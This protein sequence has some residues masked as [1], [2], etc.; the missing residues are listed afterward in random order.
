MRH[1]FYF[2][3]SY[4]ALIYAII[5]G[6]GL[7]SCLYIGLAIHTKEILTTGCGEDHYE[8]WPS[9][10]STIGDMMPERQTWRIAFVLC[11]PFRLGA[12]ISL[13][14]VFW[15]RS[16][17]GMSD[18]YSFRTSMKMFVSSSAFLSLLMFWV[19][20]WRLVGACIW[21]MVASFESLSYHNL[22]FCPYIFL[23]FV[24]QLTLTAL[25]RRNRYN[26]AIYPTQQDASRSLLLKRICLW[27]ETVAS[28]GVVCSYTY[29]FSTCANGSFSMSNMFEWAFGACNIIYDGSAWYDLKQ[30]GWWL[31]ATPG[32]YR[33]RW[34]RRSSLLSPP[35]PSVVV[36]GHGGSTTAAAAKVGGPTGKTD[37]AA[38][39]SDNVVIVPASPTPPADGFAN[40]EKEGF[41]GSDATEETVALTSPPRTTTGEFFLDHDVI[42]HRFSFCSAPSRLSLWLCDIYWAHFFFEMVVHLIEHMYFMPLIAMSLSWEMSSILVIGIPCLLRIGK[43]RRWATGPCPFAR[44]WLKPSHVPIGLSY[45]VVPM[46]VFFY[47]MSCLSHLHQVVLHDPGKKILVV[48]A[49]PLFLY[50]GLFTRFLYPSTVMLKRSSSEG[51]EDSRR[52]TMATPL[53]LVLCMLLRFLHVGVSPFYTVPFYGCIFGIVLGLTF[54]TVIYRHAMFGNALKEEQQTQLNRRGSADASPVATVNSSVNTPKARAA[55]REA[56]SPD[57]KPF[58]DDDGDGRKEGVEGGRVRGVHFSLSQIDE[59]NENTVAAIATL[60]PAPSPMLLGILFGSISSLGVTFFNCANYIPR[61]L[62]VD[63]YPT[64]LI[65]VAVFTLGL[66]YSTDILPISLVLLRPK[67]RPDVV[68][69]ALHT[70]F[71]GSWTRFGIVLAMSTCLML[72][73]TRQTNFTYE[74]PHPGYPVTMDSPKAD[75]DIKYWAAQENFWGSKT[76]ALL[77]GLGFTFCIGVL[78]PFVME[79]TWAHQSDRR[80]AHIAEAIDADAVISR[81]CTF[82]TSFEFAWTTVVI[83]SGILYALCISY[84][85]VPMGWLV[86]EKSR[87]LILAHVALTYVTAWIVARRIRGSRAVAS[88]MTDI[89]AARKQRS[90]QLMV[91]LIILFAFA[92]VFLGYITMGSNAGFAAKK[93]TA[94]IYQDEVLHMHK[95]L[96]ELRKERNIMTDPLTKEFATV[97]YTKRYDDA[98]ERMW[99]NISRSSSTTP[100]NPKFRLGHLSVEDRVDVWHAAQAMTFFSGAIFTVHFGLDNY[101]VDSLARMVEQLRR[102]E[103]GVIGLLESDSMHMTNGNRDLV[104]Y[105][106]YHLGFPYTDYGPTALDNTYGCA[107]ITRYP[108]VEVHRYVIPSPLGELSC[109]IHA[110]LDVYGVRIHTYVGHFGNTEH[111]ADGLLQS[112][113]VGRLVQANPGPSMWLGYLVTPPGKKDRYAEYTDPKAVGK[114]RDAGLDMYRHHPWVRL[115]ER[116]GFEEEPPSTVTKEPGENL[117][118]NV[119]HK[120]QFIDYLEVGMKVDHRFRRPPPDKPPRYFYYNDTGRFTVAHPRFEFIDRY[121]QYI[122][123]KTGAKAD[124]KGDDLGKLQRY[125]LRLFDWWRIIDHG[126][127]LLSDT[128]IQVVQLAFEKQD[129]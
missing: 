15:Q 28:I 42:L 1:I 100:V 65:I 2:P 31:S 35:S 101:N 87:P 72:F 61:L 120:L 44:T 27:G 37:N 53:G 51:N 45:R 86:R 10:S 114:F 116:G 11:T 91:V 127:E 99:K 111:W 20:L 50:M 121:C 83:T 52:M 105:V 32:F 47:A 54:T 109:T 89:A 23:C 76:L 71:R 98:M 108:I 40:P 129:A 85:F 102:T 74:L 30:E 79:V 106:S 62:A 19:D 58:A 24:L 25:V 14:N 7:L 64:N 104:D 123:Y 103:A 110:V 57:G 59:V 92:W 4:T 118:F 124:E 48:A 66:F 97:Y 84:P 63:P 81:E 21:A 96:I 77:G 26:M 60:Y 107:L 43:L 119:E 122:L 112:Q 80:F 68:R 36:N 9:I 22:G 16:S 67:R 46:Y 18:L 113:F 78:F 88:S 49:G 117:D 5:T 94:L 17:R 13:F 93:N 55:T 69:R 125:K 70:A 95:L 75:V 29:H 39:E 3:A 56:E 8:F 128:E 33:K 73:A 38:L 115:W 34:G 12:T 126:V 90:M 41:E 6:T 82:L